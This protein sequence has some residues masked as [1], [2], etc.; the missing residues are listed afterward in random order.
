MTS[1]KHRQV[2]L[3]DQPTYRGVD[4]EPLG[5]AACSLAEP[6][7]CFIV[8]Q[9]IDNGA[10][11]GPGAAGGTS[12]T[13]RSCSSP[14]KISGV[15]PT[16]V[17]T[18]AVPQAAPSNSTRPSGSC[19][20]GW[21]SKANSGSKPRSNLAG[22]RDGRAQRAAPRPPPVEASGVELATRPFANSTRQR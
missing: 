13:P 16:S 18:I 3:F 17:V 12:T 8:C 21:T 14:G 2:V 22:R 11:N 1:I 10:A 9:Q 20:A 6:A 15:P 7:A 4:R 5:G 19:L